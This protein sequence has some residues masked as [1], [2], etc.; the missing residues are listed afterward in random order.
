MPE[1]FIVDKNTLRSPQ[2]LAPF[3][4]ADPGNRVV[5][6]D[7][8]CME[9]YKGLAEYNLPSSIRILEQFAKQVVILR[10]TRE[11][12][13]LSL[14]SPWSAQQFVDE[15]QTSEFAEFCQHV[16]LAVGGDPLLRKQLDAY[17]H[18]ANRYLLDVQSE[19]AGIGPAILMIAE[20]L[21]Q[22]TAKRLRRGQD[23]TPDD[24]DVFIAGMLVLARDFYLAHPD[25]GALP[26]AELIPQS[27][28]LR[29]AVAGY[30]LAIDWI[31]RGG[32]ESASAS[33]LGNDI[34]DMN[35]VAMAT[36]FDG[37]LT[38]DTKLASIYADARWYICDVLAAQP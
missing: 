5:L 33:K 9:S 38:K 6:T 14:G 35:Y 24:I 10:G 22:D 11:I 16:R 29:Y 3:L 27:F 23:P 1:S 12:A 13:K 25:F 36:Y 18:E 15:A 20:K 31:R 21:P 7:F 37:I 28:M 4:T 2:I 34:A 30:L 19:A 32:I 26:A 17:A 8:C